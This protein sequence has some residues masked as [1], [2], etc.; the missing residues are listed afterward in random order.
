MT[1][2]H[3][4][5]VGLMGTGKTTVGKRA[6]RDLG[7]EFHDSDAEIESSEGSSIREI[8]ESRGEP[9]FRSLESDLLERLLSA[10]APIVLATG[11][12]VVLAEANRR[13]LKEPHHVVWLRASVGT[14]ES[15]LRSTKGVGRRPL[16]DGNL[17]E[18]LEALSHE[19][20]DLYR[21]VAT[22]CIDV[23]GLDSE[24]VSDLVVAAVRSAER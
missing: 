15:R 22:T 16:L 10:E 21:E 9:A 17:R 11:G 24:R 12:G 18:R 6:A 23:D 19:R 7:H 1:V 3:V 5:L 4:V 2:S 8:F 13:L 14:L 20:N